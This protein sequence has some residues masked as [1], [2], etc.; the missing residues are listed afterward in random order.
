VHT[1]ALKDHLIKVEKGDPVV[2]PLVLTNGLPQSTRKHCN[3]VIM[4]FPEGT[5]VVSNRLPY[6]VPHSFGGH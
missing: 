1:D 4:P 2:G 6:V 5:M 3:V